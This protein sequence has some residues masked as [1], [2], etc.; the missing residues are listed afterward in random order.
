MTS[1]LQT[2]SLIQSPATSSINNE[3]TEPSGIESVFSHGFES[4]KIKT[5]PSADQK[6]SGTT[7]VAK[8]A[9]Y[10]SNS[11]DTY[12][13][14]S[15]YNKDSASAEYSN[16]FSVIETSPDKVS[17][18][19]TLESTKGS[20]HSQVSN[21]SVVNFTTTEAKSSGDQ[22]SLPKSTKSQP[23]PLDSESYTES[24]AESGPDW[25]ST[26]S[27]PESI[28][29]TEDQYPTSTKT[30]LEKDAHSVLNGPKSVRKL[31]I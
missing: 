16:L 8:T 25:T 18:A 22:N 14:N 9:S 28:F 26:A 21:I 11:K 19:P 2:E 30:S 15:E 7:P 3:I 29:I 4:S 6:I 27:T 31:K 23:S 20:P 1:H 10:S 24:L 13:P 12:S 5:S 17:T